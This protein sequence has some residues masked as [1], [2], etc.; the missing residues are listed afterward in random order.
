M[1]DDL[2]EGWLLGDVL[3][4]RR[5]LGR[6][7]LSDGDQITAEDVKVL[8]RHGYRIEVHHD[9]GGIT[10]LPPRRPL[11]QLTPNQRKARRRRVRTARRRQR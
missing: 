3:R 1:T 4:L 5:L 2:P 8:Q 10:L 7:A 11:A 6:S 9:T